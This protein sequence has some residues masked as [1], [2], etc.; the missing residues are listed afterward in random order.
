MSCVYKPSKPLLVPLYDSLSL[1][2]K[3]DSICSD[4]INQVKD[5]DCSMSLYIQQTDYKKY[6]YTLRAGVNLQ[7]EFKVWSPLFYVNFKNRKIFVFCGLESIFN[8]NLNKIE[9]PSNNNRIYK[10]WSINDSLDIIKVDTEGPPPF[11]KVFKG[12]NSFDSTKIYK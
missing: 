8:I 2:P 5:T 7:R 4:F 6:I 3:I 12:L 9:S 11:M 10:T 1:N